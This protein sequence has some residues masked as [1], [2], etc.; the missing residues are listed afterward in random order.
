MTNESERIAAA[1]A[2][3]EARQAAELPSLVA[4][5]VEQQQT[6]QI[7]AANGAAMIAAQ[8]RVKAEK[9][10]T[11]LVAVAQARAAKDALVTVTAQW[12][13]IADRLGHAKGDLVAAE[14]IS[15]RC[16]PPDADDYPTPEETGRWRTRRAELDAEVLHLTG[17]V[18]AEARELDDAQ[19]K[20]WESEVVFERAKRVEWE[21][22]S[23]L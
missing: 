7:L 10:A 12:Q 15:A 16:A 6:R 18:A 11:H 1:R 20:V 22:R 3:V 5:E 8:K 4:Q 14:K 21:A 17:K 23:D 2:I 9:V 13:Q 19:N